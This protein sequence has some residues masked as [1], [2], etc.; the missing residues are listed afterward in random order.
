VRAYGYGLL[1]A[2]SGSP[3][4]PLSSHSKAEPVPSDEHHKEH[5]HIE[6]KRTDQNGDDRLHA[7]DTNGERNDRDTG[8]NSH[9]QAEFEDQRT[10]GGSPDEHGE[11]EYDLP[12]RDRML[13]QRVPNE[14][15][16]TEVIDGSPPETSIDEF[17]KPGTEVDSRENEQVP[18]QRGHR[19]RLAQRRLDPGSEGR[20]RYVSVST[21]PIDRE[22]VLLAIQPEQDEEVDAGK[23]APSFRRRC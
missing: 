2:D 11:F 14:Q 21:E 20:H 12:E 13:I 17:I 3:I 18:L 10:Y 6:E 19:I 23:R 1:D 16:S 4:L 22:F 8:E 7:Q 9:E 5:E 15:D